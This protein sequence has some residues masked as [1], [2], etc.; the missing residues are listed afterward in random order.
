MKNVFSL[1]ALVVIFSACQ[2]TQYATIPAPKFEHFESSKPVQTVP[3]MDVPEPVVEASV[4]AP[5][6]ASAEVVNSSSGTSENNS[7]AASSSSSS[8]PQKLTFKQ[9]VVTKMLTRKMVK[10]QKAQKANAAGKTN[11]LSIISAGAGVAGLVLFFIYPF[12]GILLALAAV[13]LGFV[14]KSQIK[15]NDE[16]GMG[17]AITGIVTGFLTFFI[18]LLAVAFIAALLSNA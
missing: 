16:R 14:G 2:R 7:V 6:E 5:V 3:K 13:I 12:V 4:A 17:W 11:T 15:R 1:F 10:I 18:L 8:A 9:R